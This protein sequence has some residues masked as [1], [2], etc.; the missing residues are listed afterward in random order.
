MDRKK[1][2]ALQCLV[3]AIVACARSSLEIGRKRYGDLQTEG[4]EEEEEEKKKRRRSRRLSRRSGPKT[5]KMKA[6]LREGG[7]KEEGAYFR[8]LL[9]TDMGYPSRLL[10]SSRLHR[11]F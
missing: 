4:R 8:D 5:K 7:G 2:N 1:E 11:R 9:L 3:C 6:E 10:G